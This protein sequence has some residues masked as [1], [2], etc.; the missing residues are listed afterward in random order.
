LD[1]ENAYYN[2]PIKEEDKD[3][4]ASWHLLV[5]LDTK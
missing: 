1:K 4:L 2:I 5:V 3:R